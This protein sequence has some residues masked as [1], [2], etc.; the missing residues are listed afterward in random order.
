MRDSDMKIRLDDDLKQ[1][2]FDA[3]EVLDITAS[4]RVRQMMKSWVQEMREQGVI[5][6]PKKQQWS[7][8]ILRRAGK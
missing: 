1:S 8:A 3:C 4:Q 6:T 7:A 2:F 5:S